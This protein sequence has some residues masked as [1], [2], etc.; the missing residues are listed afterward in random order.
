MRISPLRLSLNVPSP[1]RNLFKGHAFPDTDSDE[2]VPQSMPASKKFELSSCQQFGEQAGRPFSTQVFYGA[3]TLAFLGG[4]ELREQPLLPPRKTLVVLHQ[5]RQNAGVDMDGSGGQ[6]PGLGALAAPDGELPGGWIEVRFLEPGHFTTP[7]AGRGNQL[8]GQD[9][10]WL[11]FLRQFDQLVNVRRDQDHPFAKRFDLLSAWIVLGDDSVDVCLEQ[12]WISTIR[13]D[14][15]TFLDRQFVDAA[16]LHRPIQHRFE[17]GHFPVDRIGFDLRLPAFGDVVVEGVVVQR[18]DSAI[19]R[20]VDQV[21]EL[22]MDPAAVTIAGMNGQV[23]PVLIDE[24]ADLERIAIVGD[25]LAFKQMCGLLVGEDDV[26]NGMTVIEQLAGPG[27]P[28]TLQAVE[29]NFDSLLDPFRLTFV[30]EMKGLD[31][32]AAVP[33]E[34]DGVKL[35]SFS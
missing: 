31:L 6:P 3:V 35:S 5:Q 34:L 4:L 8:Q 11:I 32:L 25:G 14:G 12:E 21:F 28:T 9:Q 19:I 24:L 16:G 2:P 22:G 10:D 26:Q 23:L 7:H 30:F 27:K 17:T 33:P 1:L 13:F 20:D 15:G 18:R 29:G